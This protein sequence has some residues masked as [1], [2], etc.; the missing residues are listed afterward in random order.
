LN[1]GFMINKKKIINFIFVEGIQ[2]Y[3]ANII[4]IEFNNFVKKM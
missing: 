4:N 2:N 1:N 3:M